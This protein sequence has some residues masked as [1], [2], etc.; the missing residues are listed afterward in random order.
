MVDHLLAAYEIGIG[1]HRDGFAPI[2]NP[3]EIHVTEI[4]AGQVYQD[5]KVTIEAFAVSHG[6]LEA[7]GYKFVTSDKTI[8]I[9]GDTCPQETLIE[10]ATGCDILVHEV[11]SAEQFKMRPEG[12]QKYHSTVH[13]SATELAEIANKAQPKLLILTHQ[14]YWGASDESLL[15]EVTSHYTGDVISGSDLELF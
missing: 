5:D 9:S 2:D 1:E 11:Y 12:W 8:V 15:C 6:G 4:Q 7:Y 13:T 14:L 10:K 3:L